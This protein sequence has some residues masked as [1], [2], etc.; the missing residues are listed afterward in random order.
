MLFQPLPVVRNPLV[1]QEVEELGERRGV[2]AEG[3]IHRPDQV[4]PRLEFIRPGARP[5]NR[6]PAV[7][8]NEPGSESEDGSVLFDIQQDLGKLRGEDLPVRRDASTARDLPAESRQDDGSCLVV[9]LVLPP[10]LEI[11]EEIP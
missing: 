9:R 11:R 10:I 5:V 7:R 8:G 2:S 3:L 1:R 6:P 4:T